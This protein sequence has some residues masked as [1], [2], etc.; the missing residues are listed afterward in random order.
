MC[1]HLV[2]ALTSIIFCI[3]VFPFGAFAT[4]AHTLPP[5]VGPELAPMTYENAP[6]G[7]L[8]ESS[9]ELL[10]YYLS[11]DIWDDTWYSLETVR[12]LLTE[13]ITQPTVLTDDQLDSMLFGDM[14]GYKTLYKSCEDQYDV[15]EKFFCALI[16]METGHMTSDLWLRNNNAGGVTCSN[17][18]NSYASPEEGIVALAKLLQNQYLSPDG[19]YY[20]G[21]TDVIGI[22]QHY[23]TNPEWLKLYV[24]VRILQEKCL[25]GIV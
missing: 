24:E 23:N 17:G 22:A 21:R 15:N 6:T 9:D 16:A 12:T 18:Y 4:E 2:S 20:S 10:N 14:K 19:A 5:V 25:G 3:C 13:D 11:L 7:E 8:E 1:K